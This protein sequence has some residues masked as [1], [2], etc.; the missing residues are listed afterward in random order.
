M[1]IMGGG[2]GGQNEN[3]RQNLQIDFFAVATLSH[4]YIYML[5]I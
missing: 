5:S 3:I 2:G 4:I 1:C